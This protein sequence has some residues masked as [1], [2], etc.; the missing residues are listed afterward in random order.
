MKKWRKISLVILSGIIIWGIKN[1]LF[2]SPSLKV[3][4]MSPIKGDF[5]VYVYGEGEIVPQRELKVSSEVPG[6]IKWIAALGEVVEE[7]EPLF[8]LD[9]EDLLLQEKEVEASFYLAEKNFLLARKKLEDLKK[10][11]QAEAISKNELKSAEAQFNLT[12]TQLEKAT[13]LQKIIRKKLKKTTVCAPFKGVVAKKNADVG[14]TITPYTP[15]LILQDLSKLY[16][17]VK[18]NNTD[19]GKIK[20]NQEVKITLD[21]FPQNPIKGRV[22]SLIPRASNLHPQ[23]P[24][25]KSRPRFEVKIALEKNNLRLTPGM[26]LEAEIKVEI[27][28]NTLYLPLEAIIEHEG[29][30]GVWKVIKD[31]AVFSPVE[32]GLSND[33][34]IKIISGLKEDDLV[35]KNL[36]GLEI[37]SNKSEI[38]IEW[39]R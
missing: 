27:H 36:Y 6:K 4:V 10:L 21:A 2:R 22:L 23:L 33:N 13:I 19:V 25:S 30:T 7:K 28:P 8:I 38:K 32:T 18:V 12:K 26:S 29:Q 31:K 3:K 34:F 14:E 5:S 17:M 20:P 24:H 9:R 37:P 35:I 15:I 1:L 11:H 16:A 39:E